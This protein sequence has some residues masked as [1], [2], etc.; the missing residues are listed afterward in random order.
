MV[1]IVGVEAMRVHKRHPD[2]TLPNAREVSLKVGTLA[3][4]EGN[5]PTGSM[6]LAIL[7]QFIDHDVTHAPQYN[8]EY[9]HMSG[10]LLIISGHD[11]YR[12]NG[13]VTLPFVK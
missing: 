10:E 8:R 2:V 6:L 9:T 5:D 4:V 13:R 11:R 7:G 1:F 12:S 3:E